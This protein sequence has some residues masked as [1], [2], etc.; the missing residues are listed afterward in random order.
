MQATHGGHLALHVAYSPSPWEALHKKLKIERKI[1][2]FILLKDL[3][4]ESKTDF[5]CKAPG[6]EGGVRA[7]E[8]PGG[9]LRVRA[10]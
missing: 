4:N 3:I 7:R 6:G 9:R 1:D 10:C 8:Q 5:L 2:G